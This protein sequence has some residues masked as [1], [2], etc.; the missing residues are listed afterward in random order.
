[1]KKL[2]AIVGGGDVL[3]SH[4]DRKSAIANLSYD[5]LLKLIEHLKACVDVATSRLGNE[6]CD[7][8]GRIFAYWA[9]DC[10]GHFLERGYFLR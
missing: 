10:F 7:R 9:V 6:Q 5:T 8:I 4:E 1:M 3:M 2:R